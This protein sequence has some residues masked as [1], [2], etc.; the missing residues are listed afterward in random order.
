M[1]DEAPDDIRRWTR[2]ALTLVWD[3]IGIEQSARFCAEALSSHGGTY[4]SLLPVACPRR[5]GDSG[6]QGS[7]R[8]VSSSAYTVFGEDFR[9]R[10]DTVVP[11]SERDLK[12]G[13]VFW[14]LSEER[15]RQ[16]AIRSRRLRIGQEGL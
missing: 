3:T 7:I 15:L 5:D 4:A 2:D 14:K 13:E 1:T 12:I 11:A 16:G 6:N 9:V 10:P 8:S